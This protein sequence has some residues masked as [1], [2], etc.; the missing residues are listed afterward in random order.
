MESA[1]LEQSAAPFIG[2]WN[3]LV[4]TTNWEKGRIVCE[5]RAAAT[6]DSD[7]AATDDAWSRLAGGVSPQHVGRLRRAY[8]RFGDSHEQYAGLYWSHFQAAL[9]WDDA[10]MWLEGA[11]HGDWSVAQMRQQRADTLGAVAEQ[12]SEDDAPWD[13]DSSEPL[14]SPAAETASA[15]RDLPHATESA[16]DDGGPADQGFAENGSEASGLVSVESEIRT[17]R[18]FASLPSLP[19]DVAEAFESFKLAIVRHKHAGWT[20]VALDDVLATLEALK[21]FA[22]A[23]AV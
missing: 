2:R 14:G 8:E 20:E 16:L 17:V 5:W 15:A 19:S 23:P 6:A 4:S 12:A 18:P 1:L 10:E 7:D 9:D 3:R 21:E 11:V 13:E 22:L